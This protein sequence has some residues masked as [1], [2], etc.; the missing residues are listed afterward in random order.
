[1]KT[2]LLMSVLVLAALST[3]CVTGRRVVPLEL[4]AVSA[5]PADASRGGVVLEPVVDARKFENKPKE[6]STPSVG[7]DVAAL[8]AADRSQAIGRQRNTYGK[9]LGDVFLPAGQSVE[10]LV[11]S[12]LVDG[13]QR[14]G[15]T[16]LRKSTGEEVATVSAEIEQFWGWMTPGMFTIPFE[17]HIE[18]SIV[19]KSGNGQVAR[20]SVTG[21]G[22]NQA[23]V[24]S[25][26]NW[27]V[28]YARAFDDF[29]QKLDAELRAWAQ[30][31]LAAP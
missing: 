17:A 2:S 8:S 31:S 13:F 10:G 19:L 18:A 27:Q 20:L 15:F 7:G 3:G 21:I 14:A 5:P 23:Q 24:A 25:N 26:G 9:A 30:A 4:G 22:R 29:R 11:D 1:M 16:V 12:V 28:A 6:P